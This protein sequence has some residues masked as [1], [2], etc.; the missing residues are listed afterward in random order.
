MR[1]V[2]ALAG[3]IFF[4]SAGIG[5]ALPLA[6]DRAIYDVSLE[7]TSGGD[8]VAAHGRMAIVFHDTCDGWSTTQRL[9]AD[10]TGSDGS[11]SRTDF[12]VSAWESRDGR[13]MRF[14]IGDTRNGKAKSRQ[15]GSVTLDADGAGRVVLAAGKPAQFTLPKG[16]Q[17]P[18]EQTLA[19]LRT[20]QRGGTAF[21][22]FVFQGGDPSNL[23]F[24]TA[25]IG[26]PVSPAA[27]AAD[28]S[29]LLKNVAAWP[30]LLSF[31]PLNVHA[32]SPD[33]EV[34]TELYANGINGS[35]SLI[36]PTYTLRAK[37]VRL[38]PLTPHC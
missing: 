15:R 4:A 19:V 32:E 31:Y 5:V 25:T 30:V 6:S 20:A 33:Y 26:K 13:T 8:V 23:N 22:H 10:M 1:R 24:S 17:F 2:C 35:M 18:T 16:T 7:R 36:Y 12:F 34:A 9:I 37:L 21:K 38:E 27:L 14:D 29:S 3:A 11:E 28:R